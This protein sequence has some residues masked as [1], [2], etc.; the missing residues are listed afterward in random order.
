MV[1]QTIGNAP[2]GADSSLDGTEKIPV[3]G[4][5]YTLVSSFLAYFGFSATK[6][7]KR[8]QITVTQAASPSINTDNGDIFNITALAQAITSLTTN[9]TG[10]PTD[11]DLIM[12]NITDDGTGRAITRGAKFVSTAGATMATTTIAN[13]RLCEI[14][15]WSTGAT[16]WECQFSNS[17]S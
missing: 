11:N 2:S 8:V 13:K 4:S 12:I 15:K 17:Q 14:Y 5:K 3:S 6:L 9:L 1:D 7:L 16:V 10:S